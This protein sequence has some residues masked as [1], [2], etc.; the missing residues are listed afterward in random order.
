MTQRERAIAAL[1]H[2]QPDR[3][4]YQIGFTQKALQ[5]TIEYYGGDGF[6]Q[7]I[8]NCIHDVTENPGPLQRE[9]SE[10]VWRDEFGVQWDRSVDRDIGNVCNRVLSE[11]DLDLLDLPDPRA[12]AKW[13]G[14]ADRC[15][16]GS[17]RLV[18]FHH[19]FSL[20]ERA[21]TLRGMEDLMVDMVER[22][23]FV[24]AL[25]DTICDYNVALVERAISEYDVDSVHFGDDW[26]SQRGPLISPAMWRRFLAPRLA[27]QYGA[28]KAL[29]KFVTIHSCGRVQEFFP[30]LIDM[31]LDC[32]N[33]FQPEVMDVYEMKATYGGKLAFWGGISTQE[34]LPH[35]TPDEVRDQVLRLKREIGDGGGYILAPAHAI[36]GDA[37]PENILAMIEVANE[38]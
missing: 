31:G 9:I 1:T 3:V 14:F 37:R 38:E 35:G 5:A 26:G 30:D 34:L 20:F 22:P 6:L 25:L 19:G 28:A 8:D 4:P 2:E 13:E 12:D 32:F 29:G 17:R 24:E 16:A 36:P 18:Q 11:P 33:P 10:D 7:Q 27:R 23:S 15:V 21:W